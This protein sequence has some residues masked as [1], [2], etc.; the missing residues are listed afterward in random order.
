MRQDQYDQAISTTSEAAQDAYV[1]GLTRFLAADAGIDAAFQRAIEADDSFALPHL[2][3]ARF[4]QMRGRG[5]DVAAPLAR[6]RALVA[7][8]TPR[9]QAQVNA[10]GLL[11]EGRGP[12]AYAAIRAHLTEHPRD[13]MIAQTCMGVFGMIGFSGRRGREAEQ[14]AF[15]SSLVPHLGD[16]W[17]FQ[18]QHA[19][20]LL[21]VGRTAEA[22]PVIEASLAANPRSGNG[23][24]IRSHL[25]YENGEA[26][27]GLRYID[28]WRNSYSKDGLL[29][30]HVSW[31]VALWALEQG[32]TEKMWS[33][34]DADIAPGGAE[35]PPINIM[36]DTAS[37]LYRAELAGHDVPAE[38]WSAISDYAKQCFPKP[39]IAFADA[40]AALAHAM[41]GDSEALARIISDAAG[42]AADT[43]SRVA[44]G[45]GAVARQD[46]AAATAHLVSSIADHERLGGSRAQ[47][48]LI[49]FA[50]AG[51]LLRQGKGDEAKRLLAMHRPVSTRGGMVAGL[52]G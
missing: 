18:S 22:E 7:G 6:A 32:D 36:T 46:W 33:V 35:A 50:L 38:R 47:R 9:E 39:G 8:A 51:A 13:V 41:A 40:H 34:L 12:E 23:A 30:C 5:A 21:E 45:F 3:L 17:W 20:A 11:M 48:D 28:E 4:Y 49:E 43:V 42:P 15:T 27:A 31:H 26:E 25:Y 10:L 24:H 29:H 16:D 2:G 1:D 52:S 19:F 37:L 14:L 44:E